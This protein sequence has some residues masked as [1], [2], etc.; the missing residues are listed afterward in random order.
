[1]RVTFIIIVITF[2]FFVLQY[3]IRGFIDL[4]A[5]RPS[6][7]ILNSQYWQFITYMFL[8]ANPTHIF[9]NM[10]I[11]LLF[12]VAVEGVLKWKRYLFL[13]FVSGVGSAF[14][15]IALA[16]LSDTPLIGASG[17]VFGILAAYGFLYPKNIIMIFPGIPVP[18]LLAIAVFAGLE[19][20]SGIF[21]LQP[22]IANF[23]HLG[24]IIT[25]VILMA[26]WR[27]TKKLSKKRFE[28]E[29]V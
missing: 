24:G 7:A 27:Y 19:L 10:F 9:L 2:V 15:Y 5:L 28:H 25:G 22:G 3:L 13:Y 18:A 1:M 8:H 23:G 12:G 4:L 6:S 11:F 26:Y 20:F 16:G 29:W 17:A 21:G 14:L